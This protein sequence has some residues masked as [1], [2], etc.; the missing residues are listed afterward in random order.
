MCIYTPG[1]Y[2]EKAVESHL[3]LKKVSE[4]TSPNPKPVPTE[5]EEKHVKPHNSNNINKMNI[6]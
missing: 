5:R 6:S 4:K 3:L 2:I 1:H